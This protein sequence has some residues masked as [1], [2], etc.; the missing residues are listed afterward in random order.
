SS[1]R[2]T[3]IERLWVE[4]GSQFVRRWRAFFTRLERMHGLDH[5]SPEHLWLIHT[6]F[7]DRINEDAEDFKNNWNSHPIRGEA[8]DKSPNDMYFL[9]QARAGFFRDGDD[10]ENIHPE[11]IRKYYGVDGSS[12]RTGLET[13]AG[14]PED[15]RA[16]EIEDLSNKISAEQQ[17]QVK[18]SAVK[19]PRHANPFIS[20]SVAEEVFFSTLQEV[21]VSGVLSAGYGVLPHEWDNG[22]YPDI[23]YLPV[24][25][26]KKPIMLSLA[27][28]IWKARAELW[29]QGLL[30]LSQFS[31]QN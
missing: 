6:L 3:R 31:M 24:G 1:T 26:L 15:E 29:A 14:H 22:V 2:N 9:G 11:T 17:K 30:V 13:G 5:S 27:D 16:G 21:I 4:V 7:L 23:E 8:Y 10:C 12:H 28:P 18:H 25:R 19:V 20:G